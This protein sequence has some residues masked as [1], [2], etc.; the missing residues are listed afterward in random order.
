MNCINC[1][2][3][4]PPDTV[5]CPFCIENE[6]QKLKFKKERNKIYITLGICCLVLA[7]IA[8]AVIIFMPDTSFQRSMESADGSYAVAALCEES[9]DEAANSRY[10]L[11]LLDAL[12]DIEMKYNIQ[13][14]GYNQTITALRQ[15]YSVQNQ[16]V[17][18][19]AEEIWSDVERK[20]FYQLLNHKRTEK[21]KDELVWSFDIAAAAESVADEYRA[22]GPLYQQNAEKLIKNLF[23]DIKIESM[24]IYALFNTINAQ[25]ALVKYEDDS[26]PSNGTD[27]IVGDNIYIVGADAVYN[28]ESGLWSFFILT[29]SDAEYK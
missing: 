4:I 5:Q 22:V 20:R 1:G 24:T 16:V 27:L 28:E 10:Q 23:P 6:K 17:R 12:N 2:R 14:C 26:D 21:D 3:E 29:S 25:D 8:A 13:S 11:R 19:R 9:P 15:I 18:D 7:L